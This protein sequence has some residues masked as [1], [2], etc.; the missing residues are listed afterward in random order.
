M[1]EEKKNNSAAGRVLVPLGFKPEPLTDFSLLGNRLAMK[2]ALEFM[3][4]K[5]GHTYPIIVGG[6]TFYLPKLASS[7]NPARAKSF[8]FKDAS[9][10]GAD[11]SAFVKSSDARMA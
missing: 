4:D 9:S 7:I 11:R 3:A 5:I 8:A 1:A 10:F 2:T 6:G